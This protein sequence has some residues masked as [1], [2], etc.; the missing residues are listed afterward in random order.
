MTRQ[1][2]TIIV[3]SLLAATGIASAQEVSMFGNTL[4]RNMV[5]DATGVVA[6]WDAETGS[7][8]LWSQPVGSQAYG[9][10]V[11]ADGRVYVGT[12]NEGRR[13][14][15]IEGDKGRGDG[16]RGGHR[17]LHLA[18]GPPEALRRPGQRLAAAR[19]LL[20]GVHGG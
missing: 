18:D 14:P 4:S 3:A 9:G 8:V 13:D 19:R 7:N 2:L 5:S 17:Q 16:V 1:A 20:D 11:V 10:P 6:E 15:A 12:N